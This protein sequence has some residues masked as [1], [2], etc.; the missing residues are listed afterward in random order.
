MLCA[1]IA[2]AHHEHCSTHWR[3]EKAKK[4]AQTVSQY[5]LN[6]RNELASF[7][8]I[9]AKVSYW[10]GA[11]SAMFVWTKRSEME[12]TMLHECARKRWN[13]QN[14]HTIYGRQSNEKHDYFYFC[15]Q[16]C[17]CC[18][19][20]HHL[21]KFEWEMWIFTVFGHTYQPIFCAYFNHCYCT[22]INYYRILTTAANHTVLNWTAHRNWIDWLF[23]S[24]LTHSPTLM[25]IVSHAHNTQLTWKKQIAR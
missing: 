4:K 3:K 16:R 24:V 15:C 7:M 17:C 19:C 20:C 9:V 18:C 13:G 1:V 11:N 25:H 8:R 10:N 23:F 22:I 12:W 14:R 21:I 2:R 5:L 6:L